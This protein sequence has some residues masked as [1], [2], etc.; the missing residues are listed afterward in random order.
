MTKEMSSF[1]P[2]KRGS[3]LAYNLVYKK[4]VR[5]DLKKL[6]K[7]ELRRILGRIDEELLKKPESCPALKGQYAGLRKFRVGG[8]RIIYALLGNEVVILRIASRL[9]VYKTNI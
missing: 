2:K 4:S 6:P 5:R 9:E 7:E 8:F 1:R 3:P